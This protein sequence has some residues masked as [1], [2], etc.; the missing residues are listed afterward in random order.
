VQAAQDLH[1]LRVLLRACHPTLQ[2]A[3]FNPN[4]LRDTRGRW[5]KGSAAA[6]ADGMPAE[7]ELGKHILQPHEAPLL[8][9][10]A[11][12][13]TQAPAAPNAALPPNAAPPPRKPAQ[14]SPIAIM[15]RKTDS[16]CIPPE[17][18][19]WLIAHGLAQVD[20][21]TGLVHVIDRTADGQGFQQRILALRHFTYNDNPTFPY[22]NKTCYVT[23]TS[24]TIPYEGNDPD[25]VL[26]R[27]RQPALVSKY[28]ASYE[29]ARKSGVDWMAD[30]PAL[31][32]QAVTTPPKQ[33]QGK[34]AWAQGA[35]VGVY[36]SL[37]SAGQAVM[38]L[39]HLI[40]NPGELG[41]RLKEFCKKLQDLLKDRDWEA[42]KNVD[43]DLYKL[44]NP[45]V[46]ITLTDWEKGRLL[47]RV[48]LRYGLLAEGALQLTRL[49]A[50]IGAKAAGKVQALARELANDLKEEGKA[51]AQAAAQ[52]ARILEEE[53][54]AAKILA[55]KEAVAG[56][57]AHYYSRHGAQTTI[58]Q[59]YDRAT[60]GITPDGKLLGPVNSARFMSHRAQLQA[61][62]EAEER[63]R[64]TGETEFTVEMPDTIGEGFTKGGRELVRTNVVHAVFRNGR[65]FTLYPVLSPIK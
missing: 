9:A 50:R 27:M 65:L 42:L 58:E 39:P 4:E 15:L 49:A 55:E 7:D 29:L 19:Q 53:Q 43:P 35:A 33:Q 2:E 30:G 46:Y 32:D 25:G 45:N 1:A 60:T 22:A 28:I 59:Q 61:I 31:I 20:K 64:R 37:K 16:A 8:Q 26:Q 6:P 5:T 51:G 13:Q 44:A 54:A 47:A 3:N 38:Q 41:D 14:V 10:F 12:P 17:R 36:D 18:I 52:A 34:L 63:F 11:S 23:L 56:N 48:A 21:A 40:A 57:G 62:A 24:R